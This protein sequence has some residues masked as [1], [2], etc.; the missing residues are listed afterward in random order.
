MERNGFETK[1]PV[2]FGDPTPYYAIFVHE[3]L[4]ARHPNG[5]QAKFL[6]SAVLEA[7]PGMSSRVGLRI[8]VERL[9]R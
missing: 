7:T 9:V 2:S 1:I 8:Q 4:E 5:G 3:D 6:E